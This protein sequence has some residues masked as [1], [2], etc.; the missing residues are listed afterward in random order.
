[1]AAT[2]RSNAISS[3]GSALYI[4]Q[5]TGGVPVTVTGISKANPAVVTAANDLLSGD[6]GVFAAVTGMVEINGQESIVSEPS[7]SDFSAFNIDSSGFTTYTSGGTFTPFPMLKACEIR[8][9]SITGGQSAE[10]DVTTM[11]STAKEYLIGL[12]DFGEA[13][14]NVNFVPGDPAFEEIM[15]AHADGQARWFKLVLPAGRGVLVFQ[16]FVRQVN[17]SFGVDQAIQ[18]SVSLRLSGPIE[19]VDIVPPADVIAARVI[20]EA[21]AQQRMAA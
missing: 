18:G 8:D 15:A 19:F 1:M 13:T 2:F 21:T 10:I 4:G 3:Q 9:F 12:Q 14:A 7:L 5:T 16:A 6:V 20:A 17:V 11:C